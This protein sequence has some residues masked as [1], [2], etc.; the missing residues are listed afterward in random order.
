M[1]FSYN[2]FD[3]LTI[4]LLSLFALSGFLRGWL[5]IL[6]MILSWVISTTIAILT[7]SY[8]ATYIINSLNL[9]PAIGSWIELLVG[10][11][12]FAI[13]LI[14]SLGFIRGS[15]LS[16]THSRGNSLNFGERL[17]GLMFGLMQGLLVMVFLYTIFLFLWSNEKPKFLR[18]S[19]MV[20]Y[21]DP[22]TNYIISKITPTPAS[23][24]GDDYISRLRRLH[25]Y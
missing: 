4:T 22:L 14:I 9:N 13:S 18:D 2:I 25:G 10:L 11:L 15:S 5:V 16:S 19:V 3:I 6:G 21:I 7:A 8:A 23:L 17:L 24:N 12:I 20:E 1:Q